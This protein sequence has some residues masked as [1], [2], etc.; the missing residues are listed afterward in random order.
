MSKDRI[1]NSEIQNIPYALV[2]G[3]IMY[4]QVCTRSNIAY[5]PGML[6]MYMSNPGLDH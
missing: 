6:D 5:I 1:E 2:V 3:S 4:A